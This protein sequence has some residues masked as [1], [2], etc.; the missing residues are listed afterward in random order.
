VVVGD[1]E[2]VL[3]DFVLT[4]LPNTLVTGVVYDDGILDG[5]AHGYPLYAKLTLLNDW[6]L[7]KPSTQIL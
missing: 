5:A 1:S 3:K 7:F 4:E 6:F 2:S